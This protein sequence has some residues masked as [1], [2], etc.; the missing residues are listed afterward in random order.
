MN[1]KAKILVVDDD[2][3]LRKTLADILRVKGYEA[4]L[5]GT[6]GEA[7][8]A[9]EEGEISLALLDL[10][11]PDM[12][13]L[14]VMARI[15]AISP[16]TEAIILTGNASM[17]TA[18]EATRQGAFSYLLKPYNMNDVLL[19]ISHGV[20]RRQ[21]KEEII[22]LA[23]FPRLSPSPVLELDATGEVSYINPAAERMF[24]EL[25]T[26]GKHHPLLHESLELI[27]TLR[28]GRR[29]EVTVNEVAIGEATYEAHINY[30]QD[31][32][33]IRICVNDI[34]TRKRV[35]DVLRKKE[36][37]LSE[38]Q[39]LGH[40]GSFLDDF[41]NPMQWSDEMYRIH[42]VSPDTFIPTVEA[43]VDLVH[44]DDRQQLQEWIAVCLAGEKPDVLD[45]RVNWPDGPMRY[46]RGWIEV[47][48]DSDNRP[49]HLAGTLQDITEHKL[50]EEKMKRYSAQLEEKNKE[51]Q[52]ALAKVK[53]L[54][55]LLPI[56]ASCKQ[57]RDDNGYWHGVETYISKHSEAD[58]SHGIC[59]E[60]EKK[61]YDELD[62]LK[63]QNI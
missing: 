21:A 30:V 48:H 6:G 59:P 3:N 55:G 11:L 49:I 33:L 29:Q 5:A 22:R 14:E 43:V 35:E 52:D 7:V 38:S 26:Q 15:K 28:Q 17:D 12:P 16:L 41:N 56:C 20:E 40:I 62:E 36:H 27:A 9:A 44:P 46:L 23:S 47:V 2:P 39:R 25:A 51:I 4:V 54:T 10:M 57:I 8:A 1:T 24:P 60:C 34:T 32:D 18:I 61:L 50:A 53:Q 19:N 37:L 58:F 63:D 45:F 42:G 31:S 13:G